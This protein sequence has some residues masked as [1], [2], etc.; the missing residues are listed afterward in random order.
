MTQRRWQPPP[1]EPPQKRQAELAPKVMVDEKVVRKILQVNPD[2][3]Q[4]RT[5][6][7]VKKS[8]ERGEPVQPPPAPIPQARQGASELAD[9]LGFFLRGKAERLRERL[10]QI[11]ARRQALDAEEAQLRQDLAHEVGSFV[12]L[13]DAQLV[14]THGAAALATHADLLAV[15]GLSPARV[16]ESARRTRR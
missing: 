14:E 15:A 10:T 3:R 1:M 5:T 2:L 8:L 16:L 13:L 7:Q 12:A 4:G 6:L 9:S 11:S